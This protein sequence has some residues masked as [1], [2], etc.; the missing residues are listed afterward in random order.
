MKKLLIFFGLATTLIYVSCKY[1]SLVPYQPPVETTTCSPD[2]VYFSQSIAPLLNSSCGT[3]GCHDANSHKDGVVMT[4]HFSIIQ[5][6]KI[7]NPSNSKLY[8]VLNENGE[9]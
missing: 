3:S 6:V 8:K 1:E 4:D 7:G 5:E 9:D 2:T